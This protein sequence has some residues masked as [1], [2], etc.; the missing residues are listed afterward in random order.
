[1]GLRRGRM[2]ER[3][4]ARTWVCGQQPLRSKDSLA[5]QRGCKRSRSWTSSTAK[6][7]RSQ[8]RGGSDNQG[9][10]M[11]GLWISH[12]DAGEPA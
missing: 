2:G 7:T 5:E 8:G 10:S 3:G 9:P 4:S 6:L 1:M 11:G 12:T